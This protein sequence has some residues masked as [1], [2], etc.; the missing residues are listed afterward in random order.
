MH[1][2]EDRHPVAVEAVNEVQLPQGA[3][4]V[5]WPSGDARDLL[6]EHARIAGGGE[7]QLA[8][9]ELEIQVRLV[10]PIGVVEAERHLDQS[11]A[12]RRDQVEAGGDQVADR[13]VGELSTRGGARVA[14]PHRGD[15]AMGPAVLDGQELGVDAGELAHHALTSIG[16]DGPAT[17]CRPDSAAPCLRASRP[18]AA[19]GP[20]TPGMRAASGAAAWVAPHAMRDAV[21]S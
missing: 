6:G 10:L 17:S 15:V 2:G 20:C 3:G 1:L 11:P 9:V 7:R 4:A 5:Q 8:D 18:R 19:T 21:I 12:E 13:A 16:D 14:D